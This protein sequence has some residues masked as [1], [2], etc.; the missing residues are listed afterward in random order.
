MQ[1]CT[2]P[3][4]NYTNVILDVGPFLMRANFRL[5]FKKSPSLAKETRVWGFFSVEK[6][7]S[8]YLNKKGGAVIPPPVEFFDLEGV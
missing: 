1:V 6:L 2:K 7:K 8:L 4:T 3:V 5:R